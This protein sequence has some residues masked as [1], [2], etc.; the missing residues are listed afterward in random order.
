MRSRSSAAKEGAFAGDP[1][2]LVLDRELV[3][4][5]VVDA[6]HLSTLAGDQ[7]AP[8]HDRHGC[9]GGGPVERFRHRCAPV[10]DERRVVLVLDGEAPDVPPNAAFEVEASED[11]GRL[12]DVEIGQAA[13]GHVPGDIA[14]EAGLVGASG[15]H[16]GVRRADPFGRGSH[17]LEPRVRRRDIGL[18]GGDF[19]VDAIGQFRSPGIGGTRFQDGSA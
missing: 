2:A 1:E 9:D 16:V 6:D 3:E 15:P 4:D 12:A 7:V 17:R 13:L 14:L 19:R 11:Q 10:D 8:P 18:L 5:L